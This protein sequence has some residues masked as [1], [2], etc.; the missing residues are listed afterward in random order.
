[1]KS[2]FPLSSRIRS[3]VWFVILASSI[4]AFGA[5]IW[6]AL[7]VT[8]LM[9]SPA[10]P[11]AI[12]VMAFVLWLMWQYLGG[13]WWPRSNSDARRSYLRANRVSGTVFTWA[14][15]AGVLSLVALA[16][17]WIVL[18]E[19]TG[20][21]GNP[22]IPSYSQYPPLIVLLGLLMGSLV[23]PIT[24]EAA[25]RGYGQVTLERVFPAGVAIALASI[26]FALWHGPTQG[27]AW[28]KLLFYFVV[29]V[30]F[31][32][33]AYLTNSIL[34]ALPV[35]ILGDLTFFFLIWPYDPARPLV[36]RNGRD[37]WFGIY[38]GQAIIFTA[39]AL[40]AFKQ[41]ARVSAP[42]AP[43]SE[44]GPTRNRLTSVGSSDRQGGQPISGAG[45]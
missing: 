3:V 30:V 21:G 31:G 8:N 13:R 39:L 4:S 40:L 43:R 41:L 45:R 2:M 25:F 24:E 15:V 23:S 35:H 17:Y 29:G 9:T 11:W 37:V 34:P 10:I 26:L 27:F 28:S 20:V 5:G 1:M 14:V 7:I 32:T 42:H 12:L 6:T 36:W 16:G 18:V 22:T 19:L 38:S 44:S 33:T